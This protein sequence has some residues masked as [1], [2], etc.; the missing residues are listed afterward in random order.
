MIKVLVVTVLLSVTDLA[1]LIRAI[2][3]REWRTVTI[4]LMFVTFGIASGQIYSRVDETFF[5]R[6]KVLGHYFENEPLFAYIGAVFAA[7][8]ALAI[9]AVVQRAKRGA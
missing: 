8:I 5:V 7:T 3:L 4:T 9:S 1:I 6:V 2:V